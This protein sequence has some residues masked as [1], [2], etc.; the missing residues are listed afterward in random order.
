ML[1]GATEGLVYSQC[2]IDNFAPKVEYLRLPTRVE[3]MTAPLDDIPVLRFSTDELPERDRLAV[4]R[5]VYGRLTA[6]IDIEPVPETPFHF[7][8]VARALPELVIS[9][10][11]SSPVTA[12]R[13]RELLADGN[14]DVVLA[15]PPAVETIV[16]HLGRELSHH[17]GDAVL[18][19]TADIISINVA[20]T[21]QCV[22]L[23]LSRRRLAAMVPGLEDAFMRPIP[24][25]TGAL[26]LLTSYGRAIEDQHILATPEL[27]RLAVN[28]LYDLA[29]LALG[30]TR[31]ATAIANGRGVRAARLHAIKTE[32]VNGF[33]RHEL[34]LAGLAAR[35]GV[36]ARYVQM[37][38]EREGMTF[39]RFLLDQRLARAHRMLRDPRFAERTITAIAYE[40][41]FGDLSHFNRA[42]RRRYDETPSDVRAGSRHADWT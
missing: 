17:A 9:T 33:N 27:R 25:G 30:A 26:R 21:V 22:V 5:E 8:T 2:K 16:S 36:T 42:F 31:D 32:I 39:S 14:D 20:S 41:G 3:Q 34:S 24:R 38:F 7:R 10:Y 29:A 35:H 19:S 37:L 13:T 6:R 15:V 4:T 28:H 11:S 18:T 12:R 23:T 1:A 40:A